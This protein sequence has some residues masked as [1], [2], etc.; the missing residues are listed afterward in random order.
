MSDARL[1]Q[2]QADFEKADADYH[3]WLGVIADNNINAE[4]ARKAA[5]ANASFLRKLGVKLHFARAPK[6]KDFVPTPVPYIFDFRDN[7]ERL[8]QEIVAREEAL[9][10]YALWEQRQQMID[11]GY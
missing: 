6:P 1:Q 2:L 3:Y 4:E 9:S 10:A 7:V 8:R 5:L 11:A